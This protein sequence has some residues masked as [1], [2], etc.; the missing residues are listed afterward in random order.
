MLAVAEAGCVSRLLAVA[1]AEGQAAL[2]GAFGVFDVGRLELTWLAGDGA[3]LASQILEQVTPLALVQVDLRVA[4]PAEAAGLR[5]DVVTPGGQR[6][7]LAA[8]LI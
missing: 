1:L 6:R 3:V 2:T 8:Q 5:L 7:E 4:L